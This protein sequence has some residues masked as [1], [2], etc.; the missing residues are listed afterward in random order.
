MKK[1]LGIGILAVTSLILIGC[2]Q[3]QPAPQTVQP[4]PP[5]Q[6]TSKA[7]IT[8]EEPKTQTSKA[9]LVVLPSTE[10]TATKAEVTPKPAATE[11]PAV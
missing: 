4:T 9:T 2:Q 3:Q 10:Q 6:Q 8:I 7:T 1:T 11:Q 5:Q